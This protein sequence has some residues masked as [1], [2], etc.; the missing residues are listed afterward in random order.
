MAR[1]KPL[2]KSPKPPLR[3]ARRSGYT[4]EDLKNAIKDVKDGKGKAHVIARVHNVPRTT[5]LNNLST[6]R[7]M[8]RPTYLTRE[9]EEEL[10]EALIHLADWGFEFDK[11]TL[12]D[13]VANLQ[14]ANDRKYSGFVGSAQ[15]DR[16]FTN[17]WGTR[18][19]SRIAE[20][21]PLTRVISCTPTVIRK[22]FELLG[23]HIRT[24]KLGKSPAH[25]WNCDET[26]FQ[27]DPKNS[28]VLCEI[29]VNRLTKTI[30]NGEKVQY[31]VLVCCSAAGEF[32]P[33]YVVFKGKN[34]Q[35]HWVYILAFQ[36]APYCQ[37]IMKIS[38]FKDSDRST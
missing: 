23:D 1:T 13:L 38:N 31:T 33:P 27:C 9:E 14:S 4:S 21:K 6:I 10:V 22:Y 19:T 17:R 34:I 29:G 16:G 8:G 28:R 26:S 32:L 5:L 7:I 20:N 2:G 30:A 36:Y 18:L 15:R 25:I 11:T 12:V 37:L 3:A 24:L 35:H